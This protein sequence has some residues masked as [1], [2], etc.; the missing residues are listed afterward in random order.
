M[1]L[2]RAQRQG[3]YAKASQLMYGEIPQLEKLVGELADVK[4]EEEGLVRQAVTARDIASVISRST[5]T[6]V[7]NLMMSEKVSTRVTPQ[8]KLLN[9]E[10]KLAESVVGQDE[11][12]KSISNALRISRAGLHR[13]DRPLGSFLFLGPT[14]VGKTQLVKSLAQFMFDTENA[15]IR[16]GTRH[17]NSEI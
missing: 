15:I 6:P 14:G 10:A 2:E 4:P 17:S 13:H 9:M 5:G 12:V 1:E 8:E 3:D 11:A 16:I 7:A